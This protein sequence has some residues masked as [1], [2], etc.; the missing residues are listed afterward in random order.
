[1]EGPPCRGAGCGVRIKGI[2]QWRDKAAKDRYCAA[3]CQKKRKELSCTICQAPL[4]K[5]GDIWS[6]RKVVVC[7]PCYIQKYNAECS[8][9]HKLFT[10]GEDIKGNA[11]K[12]L[13][14]QCW[15]GKSGWGKWTCTQCK[16][17]KPKESFTKASATH[18]KVCIECSGGSKASP[19]H[20]TCTRCGNAKPKESFTKASATHAKVCIECSGGSKASPGHWTCTR[21]GNA[22][23]QEHFTKASATNAKL[24]RVQCRQS[25]G[26]SMDVHNVWGHEATG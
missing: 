18:A 5:K 1:M 25:P 21:C 4:R 13:C 6:Y 14:Q 10:V 11:D 8:E 17:S 23:P 9:C 3:C 22:K 26:E 20:W 16:Y 24:Y 2:L 7:R 19:G 12:P 15:L